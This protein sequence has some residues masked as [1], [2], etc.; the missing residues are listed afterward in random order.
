MLKS[1]STLVSASQVLVL[2]KIMNHATSN[3][4]NAAS[5]GEPARRYHDSGGSRRRSHGMELV[6]SRRG[7]AKGSML[8]GLAATMKGKAASMQEDAKGK[9]CVCSTS[10]VTGFRLDRVGL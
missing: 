4:L 2:S 9:V 5:V 6:P 7:P 1:I 8:A 3:I 10:C